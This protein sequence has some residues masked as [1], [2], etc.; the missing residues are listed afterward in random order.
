[1]P[2]TLTR[3][4]AT[5]GTLTWLVGA[6]GCGV[7][8]SDQD[9]QLAPEPA[10]MDTFA[11]D[12]GR[13]T[14][15]RL[16]PDGGHDAGADVTSS[17]DS[18]G[19]GESGAAEA[20]AESGPR[21]SGASDSLASDTGPRDTGPSDTGS[22]DTGSKD[23]GSKDVET[24]DSSIDCTGST[25]SI[26]DDFNRTAAIPSGDPR[27]QEVICNTVSTGATLEVNGSLDVHY[28][29]ATTSGGQCSLE[30]FS[31][32]KLTRPTADVGYFTF[33]FDLTFSGG[34]STL[35]NVANFLVVPGDGGNDQEEIQLLVGGDGSAQL[36]ALFQDDNFDS[37]Q[38]ANVFGPQFWLV[39]GALCH[40]TIAGDTV[41]PS[42]TATAI[43]G[44]ISRAMN[45]GTGPTHAGFSG[46]TVLSLG[47][48]NYGLAVPAW[49]IAYDNLVLTYAAK[50]P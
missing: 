7:I 20:G 34:N 32:A 30:A 37:F 28:P 36:I 6:S 27:W 12:A 16:H 2:A 23:T 50:A 40:I 8:V 9:F 39:P 14:G 5:F 4:L 46:P 33:D 26:C 22:K 25:A 49:T 19:G 3:R 44:G 1:M 38:L 48:S 21:D 15:A 11:L 43:C 29:A 13:D 35:I 24:L 10:T 41:S 17:V 18:G 45:Q 47:Y 42:G 31:S